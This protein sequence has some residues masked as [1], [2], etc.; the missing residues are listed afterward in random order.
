[1]NRE[2]QDYMRFTKGKFIIYCMNG[3]GRIQS[4]KVNPRQLEWGASEKTD[5]LTFC[6][7][8]W[9]WWA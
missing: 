4:V 9:H 2:N 8:F 3:L 7:L 1:M 5:K 6:G